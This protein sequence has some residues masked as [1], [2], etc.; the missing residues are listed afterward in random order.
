MTIS[1]EQF[2]IAFG[3]IIAL[4]VALTAWLN[5]QSSKARTTQT[6]DKLDQMQTKVDDVHAAVTG[7]PASRLVDGH[8]VRPSLSSGTGTLRRG[9]VTW[10]KPPKVGPLP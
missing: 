9:E 10:E 2:N 6:Q 8:E 4:I 5:N 7:A 3:V 1:Q